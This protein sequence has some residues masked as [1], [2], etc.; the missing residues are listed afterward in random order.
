MDDLIS[1]LPYNSTNYIYS[2]YL[3]SPVDVDEGNACSKSQVSAVRAKRWTPLYW[4]GSRWY[5]YEGSENPNAIVIT[6]TNFPDANFRNWILEQDYGKDGKLT[7]YEINNVTTIAVYEK[8]ISTLEGIEY[9]TN[10][11][12]LYCYSNQLTSLDVS[13]NT[14]LKWLYCYSNQLTSLDVSKNT[15]LEDLRCYSNQL[16]S[17]DVSNNTALFLLYC[18][19]NQLTSLDVSNNTALSWLYCHSNQLTSLDVSKNTALEYFSCN[20][21]QLTSIDLS[22]NTALL[23]ISCFDN[24]IRGTNMDNLISSL[25]QKKSGDNKFYVIS[26]EDG[27]DGNVCTKTQVA[28]VKAKGWTPLYWDGSSSLEYEGS[29]DYQYAQGDVNGDGDIGIGDIITITNVMASNETNADAIRRA[30]VNGD[31]EVGIGD[32]ISITNIMAGQ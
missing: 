9:F 31:G 13:T 32:I 14:K 24:K 21:N 12:N 19:S 8:N 25:P 10:L 28:V 17:L 27:N 29:D 6:S 1:S 16:T 11:R 23:F 4:D 3:I 20:S 2:L 30:D 22:K 26:N 18:Y 7:E 5:E 15:A